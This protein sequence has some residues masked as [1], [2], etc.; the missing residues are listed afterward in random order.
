[1]CQLEVK[2]NFVFKCA[3]YA[4]TTL[5]NKKYAFFLIRKKHF[6]LKIK[7]S[8]FLK[9]ILNLYYICFIQ[10]L[11]STIMFVLIFLHTWK[12]YYF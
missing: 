8:L 11:F 6:L 5:C 3:I 7:K 4:R 12:L 9:F 1:M 2:P 10:G